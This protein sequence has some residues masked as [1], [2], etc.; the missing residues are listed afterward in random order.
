MQFMK[1][2]T[3]QKQ[4]QQ[5]H[6]QIYKAFVSFEEI[7]AYEPDAGLTTSWGQVYND[8]ANKFLNDQGQLAA[9]HVSKL[10]KAFTY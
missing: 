10:S 9:D 5:I 4:M 6:E 7:Q 2:Q 8:W 3:V 1:E